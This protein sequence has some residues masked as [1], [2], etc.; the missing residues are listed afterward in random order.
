MHIVYIYPNTKISDRD[1]SN[2]SQNQHTYTTTPMYMS[3]IIELIWTKVY[4]NLRWIVWTLVWSDP[5]DL[6]CPSTR[7]SNISIL[8][9]TWLTLIL[10]N[11]NNWNIWDKAC[12]KP[13]HPYTIYT[14]NPMFSALHK[15]IISNA[16]WFYSYTNNHTIQYKLII[17]PCK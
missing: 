16:I 9:L 2:M 1:Q 3:Y 17:Q 7:I 6:N 11:I 15:Y 4:R 10:N 5:L 13:W 12:Y 14:T 8:N